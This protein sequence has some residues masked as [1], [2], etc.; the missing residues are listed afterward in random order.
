MQLQRAV[1]SS[2]AIRTLA[3]PVVTRP[4]ITNQRYASAGEQSGKSVEGE[5]GKSTKEAQPK[6]LSQSPPKDDEASEEVREHNRDMDRRAERA[7]E[8]VKDEDIDKDKVHK[9]FWTGECHLSRTLT[10]ADSA[11]C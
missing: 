7:A 1:R 5:S 9:G 2:R 4:G 8:K 6:I 3:R 11:M 10:V